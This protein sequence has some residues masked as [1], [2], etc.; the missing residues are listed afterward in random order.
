MAAKSWVRYCELEKKVEDEGAVQIFETGATN[1]SGWY[2]A[3]QKERDNFQKLAS[4]LGMH[5]ASRDKINSFKAEA[6]QPS[7]I[8]AR[9]QKLR[10][11][12]S[13]RV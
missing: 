2:T 10:E 3:M 9:M 13:K 7:G 1:V 6:N 8:V 5:A 4:Q 12:K 11:A